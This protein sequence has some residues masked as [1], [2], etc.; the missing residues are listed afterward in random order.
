MATHLLFTVLNP[1]TIPQVFI[2]FATLYLLHVDDMLL[3]PGI[4]ECAEDSTAVESMFRKREAMVAQLNL[5]LKTPS[6]SIRETTRTN[7]V[8]FNA[9]K[10]QEYL[11]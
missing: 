6:D 1:V 10:T 3:M 7:R 8:R 11:F 5:S 2:P 4:F 9:V